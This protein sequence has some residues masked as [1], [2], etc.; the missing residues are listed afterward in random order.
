M[1][2]CAAV[3]VEIHYA[4]EAVAIGSCGC[5]VIFAWRGEVTPERV[6]AGEAVLRARAEE[7]PRAIAILNAVEDGAP[8]PSRELQRHMRATMQEIEKLAAVGIVVDGGPAWLEMVLDVM[9]SLGLGMRRSMVQK[10]TSSREEACTWL[11]RRCQHAGEPTPPS[12]EAL[13]DALERVKR[14]ILRPEESAQYT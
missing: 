3:T 8:L 5:V 6:A 10:H 9:T 1:R 14:A 12:R 4:D 2:S 11:Q 7:C 13:L